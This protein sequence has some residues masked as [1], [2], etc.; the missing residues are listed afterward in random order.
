[1]IKEFKDLID[2]L[3]FSFYKVLLTSWEI[4]A[5]Y[6]SGNKGISKNT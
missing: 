6:K 1:M 5:F 3:K 2:N 4:I